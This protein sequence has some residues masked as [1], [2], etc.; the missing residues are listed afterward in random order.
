MKKI[1]IEK[2]E[3]KSKDVPIASLVIE[4]YKTL[5]KSYIKTNKMLTIIIIFLLIFLAV[6]TTYIILYWDSMHS[7]VGVIQGEIKD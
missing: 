6:E 5:N 2:Q 1:E 3:N 4:E 7:H